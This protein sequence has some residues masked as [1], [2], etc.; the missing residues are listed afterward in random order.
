LFT[1]I[2]VPQSYISLDIKVSSGEI[3]IIRAGFQTINVVTNGRVSLDRVNTTSVTASTTRGDI[4]VTGI[5]G[6]LTTMNLSTTD[7]QINLWDI[8]MVNET[9]AVN[10]FSKRGDITLKGLTR[11]SANLQ[12]NNGDILVQVPSSFIAEF[13]LQGDKIDIQGVNTRIEK[14]D[15]NHKQGSINGGGKQQLTVFSSDGEVNLNYQ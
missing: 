11:G 15:K 3:S 7:G 9:T 1:T 12:T 6:Q 8:S 10:L 2:S 4:T 14:D 5:S 13:D